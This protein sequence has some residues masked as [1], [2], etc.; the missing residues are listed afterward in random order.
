[1]NQ[2]EIYTDGACSCNP[3]GAG[4]YGVILLTDPPVKLAGNIKSP[5]TNNRAELMAVIVAI[6]HAQTLGYYDL[7][8]YSDS[9]YVVKTL[10]REYRKKKNKDLW[11]LAEL[12]I[13]T[14][15][16][17][18][19]QWVRGHNGDVNNEIADDLALIGCT[20]YINENI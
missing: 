14:L 3:G 1:M 16:S 9:Q 11:D 4:G 7:I 17:C 15:K 8:I 12:A 10:N 20:K 18:Q 2:L 5:T 6:F 13:S 19:F